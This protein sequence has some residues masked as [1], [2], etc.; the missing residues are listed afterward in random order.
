MK[1]R[2]AECK[3]DM[4]IAALMAH[5]H[6]DDFN[7]QVEIIAREITAKSLKIKFVSDPNQDL[8]KMLV[9]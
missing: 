4:V 5:N 9:G 3:Y 1:E 7:K 2:I 8:Y 6:D